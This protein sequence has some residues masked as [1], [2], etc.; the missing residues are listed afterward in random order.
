MTAFQPVKRYASGAIWTR[1]IAGGGGHRTSRW[2][3]S[4][5]LPWWVDTATGVS[6]CRA[7]H[8]VAITAG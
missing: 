2:R 7:R 6:P 8:G 4:S 1:A 3:G 5:S